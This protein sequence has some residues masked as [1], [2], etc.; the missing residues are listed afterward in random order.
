M[1]VGVNE[2]QLIESFRSCAASVR[3]GTYLSQDPSIAPQARG[4]FGAEWVWRHPG[5]SLRRQTETSIDTTGNGGIER[6]GSLTTEQRVKSQIPIPPV[7]IR[8]RRRML[9][10]GR[11]R[12]TPCQ[13]QGTHSLRMYSKVA[14]LKS[15]RRSLDQTNRLAAT[16]AL[17]KQGIGQVR[18]TMTVSTAATEP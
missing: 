16:L 3:W 14:G 2:S 1:P 18:S 13:R 17:R 4:R 7:W 6:P 9:A 5:E 12:R 8:K 10:C 15:D 11:S